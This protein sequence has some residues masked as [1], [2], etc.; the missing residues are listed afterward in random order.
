MGKVIPD[1]RPKALPHIVSVYSSTSDFFEFKVG[2][3]QAA[4][5]FIKEGME[6]GVSIQRGD[7][8]WVFLPATSITLIRAAPIQ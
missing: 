1:R 6:K 7:G 8:S 2:S 3:K 5:D 4:E